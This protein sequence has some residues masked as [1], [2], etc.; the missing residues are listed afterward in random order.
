MEFFFKHELNGIWVVEEI[1]HLRRKREKHLLSIVL[2]EAFP[3][4]EDDKYGRPAQQYA[5]EPPQ[6]KERVV[7]DNKEGRF[8]TIGRMDRQFGEK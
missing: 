1:T 2:T 6:K 4:G 8:L 5:E 7:V 3:T